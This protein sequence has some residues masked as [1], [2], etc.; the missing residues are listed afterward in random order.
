MIIAV[1]LVIVFKNV[2]TI[3]FVLKGKPKLYSTDP[4]REGVVFNQT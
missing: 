3:I 1:M 2:L 4:V